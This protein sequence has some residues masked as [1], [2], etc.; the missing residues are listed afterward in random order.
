MIPLHLHTDYSF[1]SIINLNRL[2][3]IDAPAIVI[4]DYGMFNVIEFY[5]I[6]KDLGKK[7]IIGIDI[8]QSFGAVEDIKRE[9]N[10]FGGR[11]TL[12]AMNDVGYRN[13][14]QLTTFSH[15][16]GL[17][18]VPRVDIKTLTKY[19]DGIICMVNGLESISAMYFDDNKLDKAW[20]ELDKLK[21]LFG[22]RLY[23]ELLAHNNDT[24][25]KNY[26]YFINWSQDNDTLCVASSEIRYIKSEEY[27]T[28]VQSHAIIN[29]I[30]LDVIHEELLIHNDYYYKTEEDFINTP[31]IKWSHMYNTILLTERIEDYE[32]DKSE[33]CVPYIEKTSNELFR[34]LLNTQLRNKGLTGQAYTDRLTYEQ[35]VIIKYGYVDYF[36]LVYDI[37]DY[38]NRELSGYLSAG[39]GSVGGSLVAYLLGITRIDPIN[40]CGFGMEIPFDR[41]LNAGRKVMPDIDMDFLPRDR[42]AIIDYLSSR[43]GEDSVKKMVTKVTLGARAA[44]RDLA[45]IADKLTPAVDNIVKSFPNDQ[46]LTLSMVKDS[47]IYESNKDNKDFV[48]VFDHAQNLEGLP[49]NFGV[50]ASGIALGDNYMADIVPFFKHPSGV[51]VCQYNQDQ[52]E[53]IGVVKLDVL[54]LNV[55]QI[56]HDAIQMIGINVSINEWLENIPINDPMVYEFLNAGHVDGVFQWDTYNYKKVINDVRPSNFKELVDLNTLGRSAALISGLKDKY[57]KRKNGLQQT[58]PLHPSLFGMMSQTYELP[59]YQEQVMKIFVELANYSMSEADDVRK[60]IGKKI[61]EVLDKQ[62]VIF[63]NRCLQKGVSKEDIDTIWKIIQKFSK[64]TWNLGHAMGYTKICYETAYL[65]LYFPAYYF[66]AY[67]NNAKDADEAGKFVAVLK[68]RKVEIQDVNINQSKV[69]YTVVNGV[70]MA[71]FSGIKYIG[72]KTLEAILSERD[73]AAFVDINDFLDR[74][75]R[76]LVNAVALKSLVCA[77]A[78]NSMETGWDKLQAIVGDIESLRINQ[79]NVCGRVVTDPVTLVD[80]GFYNYYDDNE[81]KVCIVCYVVQFREIY[82]RKRNK[83]AFLTVEDVTGRYEIT[84]FNSV[85]KGCK[86]IKSGDL[87]HVAIDKTKGNIATHIR[88]FDVN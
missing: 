73:K 52:L 24:R 78:F 71:G 59:L 69:G 77:G 86:D 26:S 11:L 38:C 19:N 81:Y 37:I 15:R 29:N 44:V 87:C 50:H 4:A 43:Y 32:L 14:I 72:T 67:I 45:R 39:R 47:N 1:D 76:K 16:E 75:P 64:Y 35:S 57:V 18:Q 54:G 84:V 88:R 80:E 28:Y 3:E 66:A 85:W 56:M 10:K 9:Y 23:V 70:V 22:D 2:G 5:K 25:T 8:H 36:M 60:A 74:I 46:Q 48:W 63:T 58:E 7:P 12:L 17:R 68:K 61:P 53:H 62:K 20:R 6:C 40:P 31:H 34:T 65:A 13:L 33:I 30:K 42:Q 79:Y 83:M 21:L 41:F 55:L 82:D 27:E 49:K 51:E